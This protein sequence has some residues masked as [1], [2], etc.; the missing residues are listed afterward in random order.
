MSEYDK[1]KEITEYAKE[2]TTEIHDYNSDKLD[3]VYEL[4]NE[5]FNTD[6]YIIGRYQATKWLGEDAFHAISTIREYEMDNFGEHYT[7]VS[8]P[9]SVC[10]MYVYIIGLEVIE[11]VVKEFRE[12][13]QLKLPL[14]EAS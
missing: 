12:G 4:A 1:R 5:I 9:E 8:E 11:D 10:N 14:K 13:L 3:D 7:D 2:R 6:Y